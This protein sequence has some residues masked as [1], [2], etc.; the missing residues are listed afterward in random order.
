MWNFD[1]EKNNTTKQAFLDISKLIMYK[2]HYE[3]SVKKF[4]SNLKLCMT[5]TDSLLCS[6]MTEDI[7]EDIKKDLDLFDTSAYPKDHK[8][9]S[10]KNKKRLGVF[11]DETESI[12]IKEFVG[13]RAKCYAFVKQGDKTKKVAKGVPRTAI[14][15]LK[16]DNYKKCLFQKTTKTTTT[17]VIGS[18]QHRVVTKKLTK[19]SLSPYDNKRWVCDDGVATMAF[20]DFRTLTPKRKIEEEPQPS[21]SK[22]YKM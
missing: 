4:G 22:R 16:F 21:T 3:W 2:F 20:G 6:S 8:C 12:P 13:L 19:L 7:Y 10:E 9:Y 11:K 1:E 17:E 18:K 15:N 5:D 14:K